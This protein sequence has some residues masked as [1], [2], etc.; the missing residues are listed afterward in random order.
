MLFFYLGMA[1]IISGEMKPKGAKQGPVQPCIS[2]GVTVTENSRET[3]KRTRLRACCP[4]MGKDGVAGVG[5]RRAGHHR[6]LLSHT[7]S[8]PLVGNCDSCLFCV[9][10]F[11]G[12]L[13]KAFSFRNKE[14]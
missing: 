6:P 11:I 10:H 7:H 14:K 12:I 5:G 9:A 1:L 3:P 8:H 13:R 2:S 4:E